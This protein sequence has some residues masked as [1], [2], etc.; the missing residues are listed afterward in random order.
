M[1]SKA[2]QLFCICSFLSGF[3][4]LTA[5]NPCLA[6]TTHHQTNKT[7]TKATEPSNS[8][9]ISVTLYGAKGDG[10]TN[11]S[12][13]IQKAINSLKSGG[14]LFFPKGQ[15]AFEQTITVP[16]NIRIL[17][18]SKRSTILLY[19]GTEKAIISGE[20]TAQ[21]GQYGTGSYYLTIENIAIRGAHD[22]GT[23][24][25][26]TS[27]YLTMND[28]E[29]SHFA[30]GVDCQFCW[31]NK[32][33]NVSFFYN[34]VAFRGGAPLN[35][36]SFINCIFS[37][38]SK[39][40]TFKQGWNISF[41]G[42]QFEGYSDA[43]FAFNEAYTYAIW[44]LSIN[45]C[46]FENN[47]K[48]ID[49]GPNSSFYQLSLSNNAITTHGTNPAIA[50]NNSSNNGKISGL[51][52]NNTFIRDNNGSTESFVHIEG[53][54]LL[55]FRNNRGYASPD[56]SNVPLLDSF[57]KDNRS[58][59]VVEE[60]TDSNRLDISGVGVFDK[61]VILGNQ[62]PESIEQ[63]LLIYDNGKIKIYLDPSKY[64]Y[65]QTIKS[66]TSS[67]RPTDC[68]IGMMYFDTTIGH[69]IWWNGFNWI[70]ATGKIK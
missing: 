16:S 59:S 66:G 32:F 21:G 48:C 50:I 24:L 17:G 68:P 49:A 55:M 40:V 47:G 18:D 4:L 56:N 62:L 15:Y 46:Y 27:R 69:P 54:A 58:S 64:E 12:P 57:T 9:P 31:T 3:L 2:I 41:V 28:A 44:N 1:R 36:N 11:D 35:A 26:I 29:V 13:S 51:V 43:V 37:T 7:K 52:E 33:S 25:Y 63:G 38:G 45:G 14:T 42:C 60:I 22:L 70:D 53:P 8:N 23:G 65:L 20:R 34:D 67:E 39:A 5:A 30:I 19:K 61:G 10:I 6:K